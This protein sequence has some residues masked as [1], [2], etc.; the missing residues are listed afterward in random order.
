[1][2]LALIPR[3]DIPAL[4]A[5]LA[6]IEQKRMELSAIEFEM[7]AF[8]ATVAKVDLEREVWELDEAHWLLVQRA[9]SN[10]NVTTSADSA[11]TMQPDVTRAP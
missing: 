3:E 9:D 8:L 11:P 2:K 1:M 4:R 10:G 5:R 7:R 6:T